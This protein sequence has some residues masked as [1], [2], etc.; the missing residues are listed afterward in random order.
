ME[1]FEGQPV[2]VNGVYVGLFVRETS[3]RV[4]IKMLDVV[5]VFIKT[6]EVVAV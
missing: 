4:A 1:F 2:R 5:H 3:H 6:G